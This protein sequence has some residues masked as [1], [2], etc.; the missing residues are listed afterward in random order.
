MHK[1][2][3]WKITGLF[4]NYRYFSSFTDAVR[5]STNVIIPVRYLSLRTLIMIDSWEGNGELSEVPEPVLIHGKK[6]V[7]NSK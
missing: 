3:I 1:V 2:L 4:Q 6:E 7:S 5:T